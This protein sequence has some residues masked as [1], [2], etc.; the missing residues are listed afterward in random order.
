MTSLTILLSRLF[1]K[2]LHLLYF[3]QGFLKNRFSI[4]QKKMT[5]LTLLLSRLFEKQV[6]HFPKKMTPLTILLSR[7]FEKWL[8]LLYFYQGF[9]KNRFSIFQKKMIFQKKSTYSTSIKAFWK[10]GFPFSKK[11]DSTYST[12]IKAPLT[13]LLSRL[14]EKQVFHF[15]K[16]MTPLTIL[17]SRLFERPV[18]APSSR[19]FWATGTFFLFQFFL[20]V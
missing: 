6:F 3:Y 13:L 12:S 7:L 17:L 19:L 1:E 18:Q 9:L 8:H 11:N 5:P 14:F 4:F 20:K 15:P 10:T 2:W 16:K